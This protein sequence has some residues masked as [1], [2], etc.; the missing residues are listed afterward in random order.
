MLIVMHRREADVELQ[1]GPVR[2]KRKQGAY[3]REDFGD[4]PKGVHK[5]K[6]WDQVIFDTTLLPL[7]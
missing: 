2:E 3:S 7:W 1:C 6:D 4:R 5:T